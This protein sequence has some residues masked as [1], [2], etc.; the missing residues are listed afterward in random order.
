MQIWF[1][2]I[3]A[4]KILR[5][6]D[7]YEVKT[8]LFQWCFLVVVVVT[9]L[10]WPDLSDLSWPVLTY[11]AKYTDEQCCLESFIFAYMFCLLYTWT[12]FVMWILFR[13]QDHGS[14]VLWQTRCEVIKV[15]SGDFI[16]KA[17]HTLVSQCPDVPVSW[18]PGVLSHFSGNPIDYG[19]YFW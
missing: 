1:L 3:K 18:C 14:V 10:S 12:N 4:N 17:L 19:T 13:L 6:V 7:V 16:I 11:V 2:L 9:D 15:V 5:I 8:K